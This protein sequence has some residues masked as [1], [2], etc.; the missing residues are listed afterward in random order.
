MKRGARARPEGDKKTFNF[1]NI[2][3]KAHHNKEEKR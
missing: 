2:Y 3:D 1:D